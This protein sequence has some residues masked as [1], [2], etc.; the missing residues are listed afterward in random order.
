MNEPVLAG[1]LKDG[2]LGVLSQVED[3]GRAA[4]S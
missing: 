1:D 3:L 4:S 2:V